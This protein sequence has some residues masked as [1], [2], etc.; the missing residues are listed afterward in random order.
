MG[1]A[2]YI[3]TLPEVAATPQIRTP[4]ELYLNLG[5]TN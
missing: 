3:T 4:E 1:S 2:P 5:N